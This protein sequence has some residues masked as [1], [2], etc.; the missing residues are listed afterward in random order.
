MRQSRATGSAVFRFAPMLLLA[1]LLAPVVALPATAQVNIAIG[2]PSIDIGIHFPALP[3]LTVVPG[4]PVYYAPSVDTNFFFY[5][6]MYWVF[7]DDTSSMT[8]CTG[9]S[10]TILQ[11]RYVVRQLLVQ[12]P[13]GGGRLRH[14]AGLHPARS[15]EVLPP[16]AL[17]FPRVG[18]ARA[19]SPRGARA[20]LPTP[21]HGEALPDASAASGAAQPALQVPT[22]RGSGAATLSAAC[23]AA[24]ARPRTARGGTSLARPSD[25]R[26]LDASLPRQRL[27]GSRCGSPEG[28][29][30]A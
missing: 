14:R 5:D 29:G 18:G 7:K 2:A 12:R 16:P 30:E 23:G 28:V 27:A 4:T 3:S 6:G 17:L 25:S 10:R 13:V 1:L 9:C 24:A 8:A 26:F 22:S 21:V 11:G 15:R 19:Y 20:N